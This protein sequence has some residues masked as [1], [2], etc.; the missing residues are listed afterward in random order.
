[1]FITPYHLFTP[2]STHITLFSELYP[3]TQAEG[4]EWD[5]WEDESIRE[6]KQIFQVIQL[7]QGR[8]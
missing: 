6:L 5:D 7:L 2:C 8:C 1:M 3:I 4:E